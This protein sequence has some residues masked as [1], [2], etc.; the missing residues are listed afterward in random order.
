MNIYK[1]PVQ[2][3]SQG[4]VVAAWS[5]RRGSLAVTQAGDSHL[6]Y[7]WIMVCL[8]L[9]SPRPLSHHASLPVPANFILSVYAILSSRPPGWL[10][11]LHNA[12][13][14]SAQVSQ[15]SVA[16]WIKS[17]EAN[18]QPDSSLRLWDLL[19]SVFCVVSLHFKQ[20]H[21]YLFFYWLYFLFIGWLALCC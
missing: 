14:N 4:L 13:E 6:F 5:L 16:E 21:F 3:V 8:L 17:F 20:Y 9:H 7:C 12:Y 15:H 19:A 2:W 1:Q 18:T 10:K 11:Q